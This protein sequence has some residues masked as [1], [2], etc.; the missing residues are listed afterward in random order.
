MRKAELGQRWEGGSCEQGE[1]A[2]GGKEERGRAV[3][4]GIGGH[5]ARG[6][7]FFWRLEWEWEWDEARI[8]R[9]SVV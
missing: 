3:A 1:G 2:A 4:M 8:D 7:G 5:W 6:V 9:K